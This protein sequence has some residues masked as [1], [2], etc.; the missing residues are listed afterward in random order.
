[1]SA[2]DAN[3][4]YNPFDDELP[5]VQ[6]PLGRDRLGL[7]ID[8]EFYPHHELPEDAKAALLEYV[9]GGGRPGGIGQTKVHE[10]VECAERDDGYDVGYLTTSDN[11]G[12]GRHN[13]YHCS[14]NWR[15]EQTSM[16]GAGAGRFAPHPWDI[17]LKIDGEDS[18]VIDEDGA[19]RT[20]T[21]TVKR[22]AE[23]AYEAE[24]LGETTVTLPDD[25]GTIRKETDGQSWEADVVIRGE[26]ARVEWRRVDENG[27]TVKYAYRKDEDRHAKSE[28]IGLLPLDEIDLGEP[29]EGGALTESDVDAAEYDIDD[30]TV[31][32]ETLATTVKS[33][34]RERECGSANFRQVHPN[35]TLTDEE[36]LIPVHD[37]DDEQTPNAASH[38]S[39]IQSQVES[40]TSRDEML[41]TVAESVKEFREHHDVDA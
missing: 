15:E 36:D 40:S 11:V 6:I 21:L 17:D 26:T 14:N 7:S 41:R 9:Q 3:S 23:Y 16:N 8:G 27:D 30:D 31:I 22:K 28:P 29:R 12:S 18:R 13:G 39:R 24:V 2:S 34:V 35:T 4:D 19:D 32:V 33:R 25:G 37:L 5:T 1:M 20:Y 10:C 38:L